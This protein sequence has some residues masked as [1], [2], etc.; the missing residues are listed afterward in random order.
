MIQHLFTNHLQTLSIQTIKQEVKKE[1]E[2]ENKD[3]MDK[4]EKKEVNAQG[5]ALKI[6]VKLVVE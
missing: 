2:D 1:V 4:N 5:A 3:R 6:C